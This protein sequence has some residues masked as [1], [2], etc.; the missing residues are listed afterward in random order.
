MSENKSNYFYVNL[1]RI[2]EP[3]IKKTNKENPSRRI[4]KR[5][6]NEVIA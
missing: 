4:S 5:T 6:R 2:V 1:G 3:N